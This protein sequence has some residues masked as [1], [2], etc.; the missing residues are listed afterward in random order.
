V[1]R[2]REHVLDAGCAVSRPHMTHDEALAAC[3]RIV[4]ARH[5]I[6]VARRWNDDKSVRHFTEELRREI[7]A[8]D[9]EEF[10]LA[11]L[12]LEVPK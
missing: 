9:V 8:I 2:L 12:G 3:R 4:E 1:P 11:V 6:A 10:A 5:N 7:D